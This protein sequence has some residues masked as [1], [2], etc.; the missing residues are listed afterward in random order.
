MKHSIGIDFG[1]TKT[2]VS[3]LNSATGRPELVRLGRDR[4]SIPT[5][6]HVDESGE[7][8]FG[9]D[10]DDMIETDP[11]GYCRAFKLHLGE[12]EPVLP[13]S[14]ETAESLA[15]KFLRHVKEECEQTVFHG[16]TIDTT[17]ITFPVKFSP[18]R[19]ESL[20]RAAEAAGFASI[21]FVPEPEAAGTAF[22]RDNPT[23][24][25]S[26][27]LVLD[28]GGGTLD[29]AIISRNESGVIHADR[30]C[31]E[32]RDDIGGEE[33]DRLLL[34]TENNL[35]KEAFGTP[36]I[37]SEED[38]P[39][40]LRD[41]EKI[42]I[43]LSRKDSVTFRKG[44]K[45]LDISREQF[46]QLID[47]MLNDTVQLVQTAL[48]NNKQRGNPDPDAILLIGGTSL[49]PAVREAMEKNFPA[50]R[51]L[52]WHHSH[53]AVALGATAVSDADQPVRPM[54]VTSPVGTSLKRLHPVITEV[55]KGCTKCVRSCP[56][57]A[58]IGKIKEKHSIDRNKCIHCGICIDSCPF[59]AI[60]SSEVAE[61]LSSNTISR[62]FD[63]IR[64]ENP[65]SQQESTGSKHEVESVPANIAA[66]FTRKYEELRNGPYPQIDQ[67]TAP[68]QLPDGGWQMDCSNWA[69]I[70]LRPGETTPYAVTGP[71]CTRWYIEG[72]VYNKK[73]EKG[74]LGHPTSDEYFVGS[75]RGGDI[76]A[77]LFEGGSIKLFTLTNETSVCGKE[78]GTDVE[79]PRLSETTLATDSTKRQDDGLQ[80]DWGKTGYVAWKV[81][82]KVLFGG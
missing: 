15:I 76:R 1:T 3:Y 81:L 25:F 61:D 29:I 16:E 49:C 33:M 59:N 35:W 20:K 12:A 42:K 52:A 9:E 47:G 39:G 73:R 66:I 78:S 14:N 19:R 30:R 38:E 50:L 67:P 31:A 8:L 17:T 71:I 28:W 7:Y 5:T 65:S 27:A 46:R 80:I 26:R 11:E 41:T 54:E 64:S 43:G 48:A 22:L 69:A 56:V 4:D 44:T 45:K 60:I 74:W 10:A 13:R 57:G 32:G 18:A 2:M 37:Q 75:N 58:I 6:V 82:S 79:S 34:V 63:E 24:K 40:L 51:V 55:C 77:V 62:Q 21:S 23:D 72:G 53:E 70:T 36:L 68:Y